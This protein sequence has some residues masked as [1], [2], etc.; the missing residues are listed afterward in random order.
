MSKTRVTIEDG[1]LKTVV[2]TEDNTDTIVN[3]LS[4]EPVDENAV[5]AKFLNR[6]GAIITT[7]TPDSSWVERVEF[8]PSNETLTFIAD[9]DSRTEGFKATLEDFLEVFTVPSVGKLYWEF[10]RGQR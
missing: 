10:K 4:G 7:E 8:D 2:I 9:N 1:I 5:V 6:T 3:L